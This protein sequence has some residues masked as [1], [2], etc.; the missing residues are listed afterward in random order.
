MFKVILE[1]GEEINFKPTKKCF[2]DTIEFLENEAKTNDNFHKNIS[3]YKVVH[4]ICRAIDG[5]Y[6]HAWVEVEESNGEITIIDSKI[7]NNEKVY[8]FLQ[9]RDEYYKGLKVKEFKKYTVQEVVYLNI[10]YETY[11]PWEERF[12]KLCSDYKK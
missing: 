1:N 12:L 3:K 4:A 5:Y 6:S 9:T 8:C 7:F 10:K 2:T 11:G